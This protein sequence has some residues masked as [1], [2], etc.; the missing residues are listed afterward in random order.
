MIDQVSMQVN[1]SGHLAE[2]PTLSNASWFAVDLDIN[3]Q[4][5]HFLQLELSVL[6]RSVFLDNRIPGRTLGAAEHA[7]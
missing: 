4:T 2:T 3:Q 6:E 1:S 7:E 5:I